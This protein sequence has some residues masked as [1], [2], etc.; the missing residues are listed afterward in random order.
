MVFAFQ[1]FYFHA[2]CVFEFK[3]HCLVDNILMGHAFMSNLDIS[4]FYLKC[5][6]YFYLMELLILKCDNDSNNLFLII[7]WV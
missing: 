2:I 5:F 4:V 1:F 7:L 3:V 6:V